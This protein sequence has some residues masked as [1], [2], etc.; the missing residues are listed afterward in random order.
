MWNL[1]QLFQTEDEQPIGT[2]ETQYRETDLRTARHRF[3][4]REETFFGPHGTRT[5][6]TQD[7]HRADCGHVVGLHH[8]PGEL[9]GVCGYCRK[10]SFC[11][12]CAG[13]ACA[14][15]STELGPECRRI[16]GGRIY[17]PSCRRKLLAGRATLGVGA[18]ILGLLTMEPDE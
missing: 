15:C 4:T 6:I 16:L 14:R 12:R 1:D 5:V 18:L 9:A 10:A 13:V 3:L 7:Y 8:G 11:H 17:C 2:T